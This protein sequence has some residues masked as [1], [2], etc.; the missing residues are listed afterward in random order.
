MNLPLAKEFVRF[1]KLITEEIASHR[2]LFYSVKSD[3]KNLK[4]RILILENKIEYLTKDDEKESME[5]WLNNFIDE[6]RNLMIGKKLV[7]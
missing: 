2:E 6:G 3:F 4:N 1:K 7:D 5:Q